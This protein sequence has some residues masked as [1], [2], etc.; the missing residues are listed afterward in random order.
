MEKIPIK[1]N[2][3]SQ[4]SFHLPQNRRKITEGKAFFFFFIKT[5][6][7][8]VRTRRMTVMIPTRCKDK[9]TW[10]NEVTKWKDFPGSCVILCFQG[11]EFSGLIFPGNASTLPHWPKLSEKLQL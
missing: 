1:K 3:S 5:C 11:Q 8:S 2:Y 7:A 6:L 9:K 4:G 10:D